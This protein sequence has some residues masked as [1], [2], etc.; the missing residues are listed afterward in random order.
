VVKGDAQLSNCI[1]N[2]PSR[3][4]ELA[5]ELSRLLDT[6]GSMGEDKRRK[7]RKEKRRKKS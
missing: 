1:F 2:V 3:F 5:G 7:P 6:F 4:K